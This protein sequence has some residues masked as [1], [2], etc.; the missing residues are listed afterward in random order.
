GDIHDYFKF[1]FLK[2]LS[3]K[4][5]K[6]VGLNW[7][8]IDP[9]EIGLNE[10]KKVDGEKRSYLLQNKFLDIDKNI[11][12]EFLKFKNKKKRKIVQF[13]EK[14]HLKK[15]INFFND[16]ITNKTRLRWFEESILHF[17]K[18]SIIFLDPD[19][20]LQK[21][22][23]IKKKSLKHLNIEE[24]KGY[25][26]N[27]KTVIYTQFQSFNKHHR[28]YLREIINLFKENGILINLPIIRNRTSPNTFYITITHDKLISKD[29]KQIYKEYSIMRKEYIDLITI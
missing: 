8:L 24:V 7:Y 1:I 16:K 23:K 22:I 10:I 14:T 25:L 20:G 5:K 13:V 2:F 3:L 18:Q 9:I 6:K 29:L 12:K 27:G 4:L 19:N 26:T 28:I 17:K 21:N 11:S 15:Y